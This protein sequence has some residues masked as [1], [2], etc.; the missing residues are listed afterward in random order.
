MRD[1]AQYS[2]VCLPTGTFFMDI[3]LVLNISREK[4]LMVEIWGN[5][6][7]ALFSENRCGC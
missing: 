1:T 2:L 7:L 6:I 5:A 4:G 3:S